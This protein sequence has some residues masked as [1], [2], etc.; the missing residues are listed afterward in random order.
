MKTKLSP[1][2][3]PTNC[4]TSVAG[5][6]TIYLRAAVEKRYT[7]ETQL[8]NNLNTMQLVFHF[9]T[10]YT[11]SLKCIPTLLNKKHSWSGVTTSDKLW[12]PSCEMKKMLWT[13]YKRMFNWTFSPPSM[14]SQT[15]NNGVVTELSP[16]KHHPFIICL[17]SIPNWSDQW[18]NALFQ[19]FL[20]SAISGEI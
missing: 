1:E 18:R 19:A 4:F 9:C 17:Q 6:H 3:R 15:R 8:K 5:Y 16:L 2:D 13:L 7:S 12:H 11:F 20:V 14:L 10:L